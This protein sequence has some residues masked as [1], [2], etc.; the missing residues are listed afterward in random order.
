M[1]LQ[2]EDRETRRGLGVDCVVVGEN[3]KVVGSLFES[4]TNDEALPEV[5]HREVVETEEIPF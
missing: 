3:E 2:L 4:A 5:I 1:G